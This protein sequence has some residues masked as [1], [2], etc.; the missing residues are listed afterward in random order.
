[1]PIGVSVGDGGWIWECGLEGESDKSG[2]EE[3]KD[4]LELRDEGVGFEAR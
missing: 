2:A 3:C 4:A 1:M